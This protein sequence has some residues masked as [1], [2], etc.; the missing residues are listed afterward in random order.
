M[1]TTTTSGSTTTTVTETVTVASVEEGTPP[2]A[3]AAA[4][5]E[6]G[7]HPPRDKEGVTAEWLTAALQER[8][9]LPKGVKVAKLDPLVNIGEGRG[10]ANYSWKLVAT[11]DKP[12]APDVPTKFVLK[13]LNQSF[14]PNNFPVGPIRALADKSYCL[15]ASWYEEIRDRLPIAQPKIWW[16]GCDSPQNPQEELGVYHF[17]SPVSAAPRLQWLRSNRCSGRTGTEC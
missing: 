15:E 7:V 6:G 5:P 10:Y 4:A 1:P 9:H 13:Q 14:A 3:A 11:Y 8:G 17:I 12:V 16:T 2:A